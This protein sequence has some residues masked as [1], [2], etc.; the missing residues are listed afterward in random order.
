MV[1]EYVA[2]CHTMNI[3]RTTSN[4]SK[5]IRYINL[6][7]MELVSRHKSLNSLVELIVEAVRRKTI[8]R[9]TFM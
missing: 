4:V 1:A 2:S 9:C 8:S 3:E 5:E 7:V 6:I